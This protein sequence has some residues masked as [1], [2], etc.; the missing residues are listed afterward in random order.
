MKKENY[1][2]R[3]QLLLSE[4]ELDLLRKESELRGI[5]A[6]ELIRIALRNET[7]RVTH[8]DRLKALK[9]LML[10]GENHEPY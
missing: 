3:F 4:Q 8:L 10:A 2:R 1:S 7:A 5:G 6:S 9:N